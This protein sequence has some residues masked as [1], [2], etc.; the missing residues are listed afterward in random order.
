MTL[1][2]DELESQAAEYQTRLSGL[3]SYMQ[4]LRETASRHGTDESL[5]QEDLHEAEHNISY[6]ESEI[7]RLRGEIGGAPSGGG[8]AG[9]GGG[10]LLQLLGR[11]GVGALALV[12]FG[13]A[14][15]VVVGRLL[16]TRKGE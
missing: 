10:Q 12:S 5:L 14:A 13:F 11:Q 7:A 3:R 2:R 8:G 6:Y 4:E 1:T 9:E 15:G 16:N